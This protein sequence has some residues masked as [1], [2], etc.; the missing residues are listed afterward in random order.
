MKVKLA[1]QVFSTSVADALE[2]YNKDLRLAQFNES[3][4]TVDFCRIVDQLFDLFNTRNSLSKNMFKKPMTEGRLPFI[5]LE[6][7]NFWKEKT[8]RETKSFYFLKTSTKSTS[9]K[10]LYFECHSSNFFDFKSTCKLRAP[11]ISGSIRVDVCPSRIRAEICSATRTVTAKFTSTHVGH[12]AELRC[13]PLSE[14]EQKY[15]VDPIRMGVSYDTIINRASTIA[16]GQDCS[17]LNLLTVKDIRYLA[18]KNGLS[19]KRHKDDFVR[20]YMNDKMQHML[21]VS[22]VWT[23]PTEL[24]RTTLS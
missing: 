23:A 7:F 2:Y 21:T 11:K 17:R 8:E 24:I 20:A 18:E 3:D 13:Q 9:G 4:T 19:G 12:D 5:T 6:A 16:E 10:T 1:V 22:S 14:T 15:I